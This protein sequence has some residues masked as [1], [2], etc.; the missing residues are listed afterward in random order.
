MAQRWLGR[1]TLD[2]QSWRSAVRLTIRDATEEEEA[3]E[4]AQRST[5]ALFTELSLE[6]DVI[7]QYLNDRSNVQGVRLLTKARLG[8]MWL[9]KAVSRTVRHGVVSAM[10][11]LCNYNVV[12]DIEHFLIGCPVLEVCLYC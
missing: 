8:Y 11:R 7:P 4:V 3:I 1:K 5:L 12:E 10:C 2:E 6:Q 9:M